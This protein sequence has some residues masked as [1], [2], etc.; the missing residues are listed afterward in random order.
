MLTMIFVFVSNGSRKDVFLFVAEHV[1]KSI[2]KI[3]NKK[4]IFYSH[5]SFFKK[6]FLILIV[7]GV[8]VNIK[9]T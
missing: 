1:Y 4:Y 2:E 5:S 8:I 9:A 3:Y 7:G 6:T